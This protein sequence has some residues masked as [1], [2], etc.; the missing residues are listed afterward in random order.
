MKFTSKEIIEYAGTVAIVASLI[1]VGMQLRL[2]R[3]MALAEVY[4]A[5]SEARQATLRSLLESEFALREIVKSRESG[6]YSGEL[7]IPASWIDP[8]DPITSEVR[9]I[10]NELLIHGFDNFLYQGSLGLLE[11]Q[12]IRT[13]IKALFQTD[14]GLQEY[15]LRLIG[16]HQVTRATFQ[17]IADELAAENL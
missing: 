9:R 10:R 14:Q 8:E 15:S 2:D 1:F 17:G 12:P 5:R 7:A 13:G 11:T 6:T 16:I 4:A 3:R